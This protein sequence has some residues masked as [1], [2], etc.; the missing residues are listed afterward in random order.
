MRFIFIRDHRSLF[1]VAA[2]CRVLRVSHSG[3]YAWMARPLS[4]RSRRRA[5]LEK[6]IAS[7]HEEFKRRYGSPRIH[8][9]LRKRHVKACRNTVAKLMREKGLRA[10]GHRAFRVAT[11]DSSHE[12]AAAPNLLAR[13]FEVPKLNTVWTSDITYIKT[14]QGMLYLSCVMDLCSR[15]IVGWST[16]GNMQME[17]VA[18]ALLG[19]I[20][21]RRPPR[22]LILHSDRGIQYACPAFRKVLARQHITQSMSRLGDCYDNAPM[23]SFWGRLKVE[24]I[25]GEDLRTREQAK[26][27]VF[28][29]I[30]LFYNRRRSHSALGYQ[31]PEEFEAGRGGA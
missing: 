31:S 9:Q 22:G 1:P 10:R 17:L 25:E 28:E 23:E 12:H 2:M 6:T 11:T 19:A 29:Y 20:R 24:S 30:E 27:I 4:E 8:D 3:F 15:R 18:E 13:R 16:S 26:A 7:V 14:G 5:D 21:D